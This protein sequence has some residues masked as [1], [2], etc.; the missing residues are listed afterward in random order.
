MKIRNRFINLKKRFDAFVDPYT[1]RGSSSDKTV[2][3]RGQGTQ[4]SNQEYLNYYIDNGFIRNIV[5]DPADDAT[6]EW[7]KIK[8]NILNKYS[9][10]FIL[11]ISSVFR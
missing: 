2:R 8:T 5:D 9:L 7:I 6:R 3:T 1:A 11:P 4:K 10:I